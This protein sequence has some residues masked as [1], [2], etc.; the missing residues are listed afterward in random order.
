MPDVVSHGL[1]FLCKKLPILINVFWINLE[2]VLS[3][4]D[5]CMYAVKAAKRQAKGIAD[6]DRMLK[7]VCHMCADRI[8]YR[9]LRVFCT[10]SYLNT[11]ENFV[12]TT[13]RSTHLLLCPI[14]PIPP[15]FTSCGTIKPGWKMIVCIYKR[16]C[17]VVP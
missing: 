6:R 10:T 12:P 16:N 13:I 8:R 11:F 7:E 2:Q 4:L 14:K 3:R 1:C 5:G 9:T 17:A 15:I